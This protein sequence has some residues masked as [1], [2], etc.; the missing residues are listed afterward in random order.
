MPDGGVT[1]SGISQNDL[2]LQTIENAV[3]LFLYTNKRC[4]FGQ[5]F[6]TGC[7]YIGASRTQAAEDIASGIINRAAQWQLDGFTFCGAV[8][9][10]TTYVDASWQIQNS[11][12]RT[13]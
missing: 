10:N 11:Y 6:Q 7:A 5:L 2:F 13:A 8:L 1:P 4:T 12:R 3:F 9:C